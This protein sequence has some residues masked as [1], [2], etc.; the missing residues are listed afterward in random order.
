MLFINP[1]YLLLIIPALLGWFAQWRVQFIY[2]Q[3]LKQPNKNYIDGSEVIKIFLT[4][5]QLNLP[6]VVNKKKLV[7][8]YNPQN[9]TLHFS[10]EILESA[11]IT[12]MGIVAHEI[13]HVIQDKEGCKFMVLRNNLA[14]NLAILGQF[15]T[16]LFFW[17]IIFRHLIFVYAAVLLLFG[18]TVFAILSLPIEINASKRGLH[19]LNELNIA[20]EHD[21]K[22][23]SLVLRHAAFTYFAGALQKIGT[24]LFIATMLLMFR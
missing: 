10:N 15:T 18:L 3:Y 11:S 2:Y 24:F 7:N 14:K 12:S 6:I 20:D 9:K 19:A 21:I 8:Y 13:A 17:G 5:Y 22:G 16:I 23:V 1:L 4:H